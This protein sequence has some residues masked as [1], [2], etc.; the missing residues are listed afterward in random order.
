MVQL[1][2]QQAGLRNCR[3]RREKES[4]HPEKERR[5]GD[6]ETKGEHQHPGDEMITLQQAV[7]Y[8]V[9]GIHRGKESAQDGQRLQDDCAV[10][11]YQPDA[12]VGSCKPERILDDKH[13]L[14]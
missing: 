7:D 11:A 1:D 5:E 13:E 6:Q 14:P 2:Q 9:G 8:P 4:E 12:L 3:Y 10:P